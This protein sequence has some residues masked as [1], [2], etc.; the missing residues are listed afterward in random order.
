MVVAPRFNEP[1][2]RSDFNDQHAEQG[3]A[4]LRDYTLGEIKRVTADEPDDPAWRERLI[5]NKSGGVVVAPHN[6]SLILENDPNLA[7]LFRLNEFA[8]RVEFTRA[9]PFGGAVRELA[10]A[11]I[12]ELAIWLGQPETYGMNVQPKMI[13]S[14]LGAVAARNTF[15]PVRDY[16]DTLEWDGTDRL[17]TML[18]DYFGVKKDEY[19]RQVGL[20]FM[21]S[22][23]A[24]VREPGIKSDLMMVLEGKQGI[25]KSTAIEVLAGEDWFVATTESPDNKDFYQIL[26]GKWLVEIEEL[27]SFSKPQM[28]KIKSAISSK[29]DVFRPPY[30]FV[31]RAFPRHCIFVGTTNDDEYLRDPTGA[32]RF[33][34]V[35]VSGVE[36]D[37][38]KSDRDQ[39]WA[40]ADIRF[41]RG[42]CYWE[43][44]DQA[45][46]E[47]EKRYM[48]DSWTH[49]IEAWLDCKG[50][51]NYPP[52]AVFNGDRQ[53]IMTN[54]N[55][56]MSYALHLD[57]SRQNRQEQMRVAA[58][59]KRL[60]WQKAQRTYAGL[61][62]QWV[63]LRPGCEGAAPADNQPDDADGF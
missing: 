29:R 17:P 16:L 35:Y 41:A 11:E 39:L 36:I 13:G 62:K 57:N 33:M 30:G 46:R 49:P 2:G 59:I 8:T 6:I 3:L 40:E 50:D 31:P 22:A 5:L 32:R 58:I 54:V 1:T 53:V 44:P 48:Q 42:E 24:R 15:H 61:A 12:M 51:W 21:I 56:V 55:D 9:P 60:G 47:R 37:A 23:A 45:E 28:P 27:Q 20:N 26:Q 14:V 19:S 52:G 38:L 7:N 63:Y 10:D 34:P 4:A 43:L 18:A 25:Y